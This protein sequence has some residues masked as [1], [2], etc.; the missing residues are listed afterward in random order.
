MGFIYSALVFD[1][2]QFHPFESNEHKRS[3]PRPTN[4]THNLGISLPNNPSHHNSNTKITFFRVWCA[5]VTSKANVLFCCL[6]QLQIEPANKRRNDQIKLS[7]DQTVSQVS[8]IL[9]LEV[10]GYTN[11]IPTQI[12]LPLEK[13][14]RYR[15]NRS[16]FAAARIHLSGS[17]TWGSGKI[18]GSIRTK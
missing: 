3:T 11:F 8:Q 10:V 6:V 12:R 15:S 13:L 4:H 5:K 17:K 14:T 1:P 7:I 2:V 18:A 9:K 16:P